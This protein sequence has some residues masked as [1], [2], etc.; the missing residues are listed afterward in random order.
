MATIRIH[1]TLRVS[2]RAIPGHVQAIVVVHYASAPL[3]RGLRNNVARARSS[4]VFIQ[5]G[6]HRKG[7]RL[8]TPP[9]SHVQPSLVC[10][11]RPLRALLRG[12]C[13]T[14]DLGH[15]FGD[16]LEVTLLED[17]GVVIAAGQGLPRLARGVGDVV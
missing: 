2:L 3:Q 11:S 14:R 5:H 12:R 4:K 8:H 9:P 15:K 17:A 16:G 1:Y 13:L 7:G 10:A 6:Y